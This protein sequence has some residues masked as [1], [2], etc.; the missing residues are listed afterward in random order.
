MARKYL[1]VNGLRLTA[2]GGG[3]SSCGRRSPYGRRRGRIELSVIYSRPILQIS[4][5]PIPDPGFGGP[6]RIEIQWPDASPITPA[7]SGS[8]AGQK[9]IILGARIVGPEDRLPLVAWE[10]TST[11][12]IQAMSRHPSTVN[13]LI[14]QP[15]Y[16]PSGPGRRSPCGS[17][18]LLSI[19]EYFPAR[20]LP[21]RSHPFSRQRGTRHWRAF[22]R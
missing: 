15:Q 18:C 14:T 3:R 4:H 9:A 22:Y 8:D 1:T 13:R 2:D 21:V 17:S 10:G 16:L 6:G 11:R 19:S 7:R 12:H 20:R 5:S